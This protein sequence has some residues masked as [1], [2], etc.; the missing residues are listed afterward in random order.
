MFPASTLPAMASAATP[1]IK[2]L[3]AAGISYEIRQF[4]HD[5]RATSFGDEAV[6]ELAA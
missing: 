1:A 4:R 5:P 2:S 6:T 3:Q